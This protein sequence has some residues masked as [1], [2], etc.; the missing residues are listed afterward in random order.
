MRMLG[1]GSE[2]DCQADKRIKLTRERGGP[3]QT[4]KQAEMREHE[5]ESESARKAKCKKRK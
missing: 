5:R 3:K 4:N 2:T 1:V